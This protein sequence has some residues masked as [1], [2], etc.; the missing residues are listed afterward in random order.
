MRGCSA[1]LRQLRRARVS[2]PQA[3]AVSSGLISSE[4]A[5]TK[6]AAATSATFRQRPLEHLSVLSL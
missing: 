4:S 2:A 3:A 1:V 5:S 6:D